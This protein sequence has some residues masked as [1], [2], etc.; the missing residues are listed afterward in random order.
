[1]TWSQPLSENER[2]QSVNDFVRR[3]LYNP[4]A[5]LGHLSIIEVLAVV[6]GNILFVDIVSPQNERQQS[7]NTASTEH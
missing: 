5:L 1:M 3:I 7:V 4:R 6:I 2:L